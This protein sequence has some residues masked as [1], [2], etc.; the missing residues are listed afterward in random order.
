[1]IFSGIQEIDHMD[2]HHFAYFVIHLF[3][4]FG[5]SVKHFLQQDPSCLDI[6]FSKNNE[7][8]LVQASNQKKFFAAD[9]INRLAEEM[10]RSKATTAW[11]ITTYDF[12]PEIYEKAL[13]NKVELINRDRLID[14][15]ITLKK[16]QQ[17]LS[18]LGVGK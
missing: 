5:Y 15:V 16:N 2:S 13:A 9:A 10:S 7:Q 12:T 3:H 14:M 11:L 1:M 6:V 8:M 4:G 18:M 17:M